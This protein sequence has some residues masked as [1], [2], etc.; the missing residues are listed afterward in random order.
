MRITIKPHR[1][2]LLANVSDQKLYVMI[3]F[4]PDEEDTNQENKIAIA[5]VVDAGCLELKQNEQ[6]GENQLL[7]NNKNVQDALTSELLKSEDSVTVI[8]YSDG[9][10]LILQSPF[11]QELQF[12]QNIPVPSER[13][14]HMNAGLNK[15]WTHLCEESDAMIKAILILSCR[16]T[17]NE[18]ECERIARDCAKEGIKIIG[19]GIGDQYDEDLLMKMSEKTGGR[20]RHINDPARLYDYFNEEL[21]LL[22]TQTISDAKAYFDLSTGV[23]ITAA[24]QVLPY[25]LDLK[26]EIVHVTT[27]YRDSNTF[28]RAPLFH[29]SMDFGNPIG[30][31]ENIYLVE[32]DTP[33]RNASKVRLAEIAI[34]YRM[35]SSFSGQRVKRDSLIVEYT[36]DK[37]E[38]GI[39]DDEVLSLKKLIGG[40][41]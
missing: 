25:T 38:V 36:N 3:S 41:F 27:G 35:P 21:T 19:F 24:K 5:V 6:T 16:P 26:T 29:S 39:E 13:M 14:G 2:K 4:S 11:R 40:F 8:C 20:A 10:S 30:Q 1:R 23:E 22:K 28:A 32:F 18:D 15:A 7:A 33:T 12:F 9:A 17:I 31:R 37:N 34:I